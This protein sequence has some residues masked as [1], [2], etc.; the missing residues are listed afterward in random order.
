[1]ENLN[2]NTQQRNLRYL[3]GQYELML[4]IMDLN[5]EWRVAYEERLGELKVQYKETLMETEFKIEIKEMPTKELLEAFLQSM[6][7]DHVTVRF[8]YEEGVFVEDDDKGLQW[9]TK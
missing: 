8:N 3:I 5:P 4:D 6:M 9:T 2:E 7:S 1:M